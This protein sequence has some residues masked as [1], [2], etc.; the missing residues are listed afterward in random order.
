LVTLTIFCGVQI[1]QSPLYVVFSILLLGVQIRGKAF[2]LRTMLAYG[3]SR[4][5][6]SR[7]PN[8]G[9]KGSS[10]VNFTTRPLYLRERTLVPIE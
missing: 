7:I 10:L 2:P 9:T 8:L 6:D 5:I 3:R 4:R 1:N